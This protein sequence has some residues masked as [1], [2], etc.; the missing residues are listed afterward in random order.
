MDTAFISENAKRL[1]DNIEKVIV[2]RQE[3]IKK[4]LTALFAGGSVLI[5]DVPGTGKTKLA[6]ALAKSIDGEFGRIQF[7][8]DL[9]PA[10]LTGLSIFNPKTGEFVFNKGP[11][12]SNILLADEINRAT[13]RTQSGL[14]ESMEERQVTAD[15]K[16]YPLPELFFP[17]ATENPIETAGTY[18]LPEA[19]LDRFS[20]RISMG[21]MTKDEL[22][23]LIDRFIGVDPID[24]LGPVCDIQTIT[25][26][27]EAVKDVFVHDC[28]K[29]YI[30]SLCDEISNTKGLL[31]GVSPRGILTLVR[32]C[33]AYAAISGRDYVSPDD[34]KCLFADTMIHRL[35]PYAESRSVSVKN[36]VLSV[37]SKVS[38]PTEDWKR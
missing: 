35:M 32:L 28:V 18:P 31:G 3:Q 6:K 2:G 24:T 5:E 30:A 38:V 26:I 20:I 29:E 34:V 8:P 7:T 27:R 22:L 1:S 12:F 19:L 14:L 11:V 23:C 15:G 33:Q 37:L 36:I 4:V 17:V 21:A 13:P 10:D 16:T 9:L 25:E